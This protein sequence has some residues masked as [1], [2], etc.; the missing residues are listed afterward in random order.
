VRNILLSDIFIFFSS[1]CCGFLRHRLLDGGAWTS[2]CGLRGLHKCRSDQS[3]SSYEGLIHVAE[4]EPDAESTVQQPDIEVKQL[5]ES[6]HRR[7]LPSKKRIN[8]GSQLASADHL[9]SFA[10]LCSRRRQSQFSLGDL[11]LEHLEAGGSDLAIDY[12]IAHQQACEFRVSPGDLGRLFIDERFAS[13]ALSLTS[14][15]TETAIVVLEPRKTSIPEA[16]T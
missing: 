7:L 12:A 9:G 10:T 1:F 3:A 4:G 16:A 5:E 2:S 14:R 6:T 15:T 8:V 11:R 13:S